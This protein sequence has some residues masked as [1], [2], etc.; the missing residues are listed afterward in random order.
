[1]LLYVVVMTMCDVKRELIL[2]VMYARLK[3]HGGVSG[4]DDI[5]FEK[6]KE[7]VS[8]ATMDFH[9]RVMLKDLLAT[10]EIN[11]ARIEK[12]EKVRVAAKESDVYSNHVDVCSYMIDRRDRCTCGHDELN[13]ALAACEEETN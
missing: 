4:M 8:G 2:Y 7:W 6:I 3:W 9:I 10:Y 1:M 13:K 11:Q 5:R 12:L